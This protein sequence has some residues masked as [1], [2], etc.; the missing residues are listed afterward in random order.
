MKSLML[1][2]S[3]SIHLLLCS[4]V[5]RAPCEIEIPVIRYCHPARP[6][7]RLCP[8]FRSPLKFRIGCP[9]HVLSQALR[10]DGP[11]QSLRLRV[12]VSL[13]QKKCKSSLKKLHNEISNDLSVVE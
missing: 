4:V 7:A 12:D 5:R 1:L 9:L 13:K 2:C 10:Y 6:L 8:T 3:H 11:G